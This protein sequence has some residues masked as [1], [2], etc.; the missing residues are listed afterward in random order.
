MSLTTNIRVH[1][2]ELVVKPDLQILRRYRR[3]LLLRLEH[4]HRP[5]LEDHVHRATRLGSS[6][7]LNL[8]FGLIVRR[9]AVSSQSSCGLAAVVVLPINV[10]TLRREARCRAPRAEAY[11]CPLQL[12]RL[13][14]GLQLRA[15]LLRTTTFITANTHVI[16]GCWPGGRVAAASGRLG[17]AHQRVTALRARGRPAMAAPNHVD[18]VGDGAEHGSIGMLPQRPRHYL[19]IQRGRNPA[20]PRAVAGFSSPGRL[21]FMD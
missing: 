6:R 21:F 19:Q 5:T 8:R 9:R 17:V 4:T 2:S 14:A 16:N 10:P 15:G 13:R 18:F 11:A 7:S 1:A 3:P 20:T 12:L